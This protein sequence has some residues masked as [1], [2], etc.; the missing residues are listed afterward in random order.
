MSKQYLNRYNAQSKS[1]ERLTDQPL[2]DGLNEMS[3]YQSGPALGP[4]G[5]YHIN[6]QKYK[7]RR[8]DYVRRY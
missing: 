8:I 3:A 5:Q 1:F 4:D 6:F 2:F 7:H